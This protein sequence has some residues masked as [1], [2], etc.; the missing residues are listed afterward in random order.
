[1]VNDPIEFYSS[2]CV[3]LESMRLAKTL[4]C[5]NQLLLEGTMRFHPSLDLNPNNIV[6]SR[7]KKG[8]SSA[9]WS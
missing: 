8:I 2:N 5:M 3:G 7:V 4:L 6:R 1:M 9:Q